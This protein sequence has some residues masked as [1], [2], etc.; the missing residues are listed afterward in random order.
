MT[1]SKNL[2]TQRANIISK[3]TKKYEI[4]WLLSRLAKRR[5]LRVCNK[6]MTS[7]SSKHN[8]ESKHYSH[9]FTV[10]IQHHP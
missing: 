3:L 1:S 2:I 6:Q 8:A 5:V 9:T 7:T 4:E 10:A